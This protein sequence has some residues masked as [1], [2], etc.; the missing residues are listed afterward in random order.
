MKANKT[1]FIQKDLLKKLVGRYKKNSIVSEIEANLN[2]P[3]FD[4]K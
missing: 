2:N 3:T 1:Q 4:V